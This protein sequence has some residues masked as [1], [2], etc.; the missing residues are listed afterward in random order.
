MFRTHKEEILPD[1][2]GDDSAVTED[3]VS[4]QTSIF[5]PFLD[6]ERTLNN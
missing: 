6:E 2:K 5:L 1:I 4:D 3:I